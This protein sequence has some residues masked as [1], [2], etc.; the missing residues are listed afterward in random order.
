MQDK[1]LQFLRISGP[2]LPTKV[3]KHLNTQLLLASA[4]LADLSSQ[5]KIKVSKLKIGG[6]PLYYL[7]GQEER[8]YQ[9]AAGN[10]DPKDFRVLEWLQQEKVLRESSLDLLSKVALRHLP[11]FALPLQVGFEGN[12]ELFWKWHLLSEEETRGKIQ[13]LLV[14]QKEISQEEVG[15]EIQLPI[16]EEQEQTHPENNFQAAAASLFQ[17]RLVE[18]KE[19]NE[20]DREREVKKERFSEEEKIEKI[21]KNR[22][23]SEEDKTEENKTEKVRKKRIVVEEE[24]LPAVEILFKHLKILPEQKE[25]VRKNAEL[26]FLIQVPSVVGSLKY[27]CKA[28]Q[29][30]RCDEKDLSAAYMEAQIKKL[31]LLFLYTEELSKKAEEMMKSG[32]FENVIVRKVEN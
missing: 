15:E 11:D 12:S 14:P 18:E 17:K 29:K 4:G 13:N 22:E 23:F 20:I 27:F 30:K 3:A 26:N 6:S 25:I 10:V 21:Q 24:F 5:G 16:P 19:K 8:L 32:A 2:T 28:K 31:P 9:F 1:I 7:P